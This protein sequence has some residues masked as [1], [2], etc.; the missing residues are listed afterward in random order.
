MSVS[1]P[2]TGTAIRWPLL[3]VLAS[4]AAV[5]PVAT[6]LYLPGFPAM[7]DALGADASTSSSGQRM[8]VPVAGAETDTVGVKQR[9]VRSGT[10]VRAWQR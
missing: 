7:G 1:A 3:F 10:S 5:A 9:G 8:A 4:L 6:D 2:A